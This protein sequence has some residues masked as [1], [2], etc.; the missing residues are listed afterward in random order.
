MTLLNLVI[1]SLSI[2]FFSLFKALKVV[3]K[4]IIRLQLSFLWGGEERIRKINWISWKVCLS[5]EEFCFGF[6]NCE[7]FNLALMCKWFWRIL[8]EK[9]SLRHEMLVYMYGDI[10]AQVSGSHKNHSIW[11]R[12]LY[13]LDNNLSDNAIYT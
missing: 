2:H 3:V 7:L 8:K 1:N 11:W 9:K 10:F 5:K 6:K 4:E 13:R 12:D